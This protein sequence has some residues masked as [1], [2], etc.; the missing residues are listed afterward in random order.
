MITTNLE[1][2]CFA[3]ENQYL[4]RKSARKK[5]G[6]L[7]KHLIG[8]AN[9]DGGLLVIG[10]EDDGS[11]SGFKSQGAHSINEFRQIDRNQAF[12]PLA[13]EVREIEVIN[14]NGEN[15]II[16]VISIEPSINRVIVSPD[17]VAYLREGDE[18]VALSF[19]RRRMLEYDRGQRFFEDETVEGATLDD[20]D[21]ELVE[22]YKSHLNIE[23]N[24]TIEEILKA[25][26]LYR[27]GKITKAGILLFGKNPSR[28]LPQARLRVFKFSG[29]EMDVGENFNVVKNAEFDKALPRVI[30]E[31]RGFVKMQLRDF[32]NLQKDGMFVTIPEYP[33]FAWFEGIVNAVTHRDY[34]IAGDHIKVLMYD[35]HLSIESPGKLPNIVTLENIK[36]ERFSRNPRIARTLTEFGWV[37]EMNEGVK[38]IFSEMAKSYLHEPKYM[39]PGN[40]VVLTLENNILT[41]RSRQDTQLGTIL[42]N[43]DKLTPIAQELVQYMYNTGNTLTT[44]E[45]AK[46]TGRGRSTISKALSTLKKLQIVEWHGTSQNDRKQYYELKV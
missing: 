41:R 32:Q 17:D 44:A 4:D 12:Y 10:V 26:Y 22:M 1:Y 15:D 33:E 13:K 2:L 18:T 24:L 31:S 20:I 11:I 16:V 29:S 36:E 27:D 46:I 9:A 3:P 5:P 8:F 34:S 40:K 42:P 43:Y 14:K 35:D 30:M 19:E 23:T 38:R 28:F 7:L 25:R 39:E 21:T 45:A 6:E 37:R